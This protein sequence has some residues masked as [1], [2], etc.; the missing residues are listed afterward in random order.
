MLRSFIGVRLLKV[1]VVHSYGSVILSPAASHLPES[2]IYQP[3][4]LSG[5]G[6]RRR[7]SYDLP[8]CEWFFISDL[9]S[10]VPSTPALT[11]APACISLGLVRGLKISR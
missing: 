4:R 1:P 5:R 10:H 2:G 8:K 3:W 7:G 9:L 11:A 6:T